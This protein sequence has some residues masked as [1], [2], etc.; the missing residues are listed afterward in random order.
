MNPQEQQLR[1]IERI[2]GVQQ[3]YKKT[4]SSEEGKKVLKDL[5]QICLA[6]STT[7]NKDSLIMAFQEGLR[8]VYLHI[9]TMININLDELERVRNASSKE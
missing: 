8:S 9:N 2:K 1:N 3:D 7:F 5:E 6:N 4:F